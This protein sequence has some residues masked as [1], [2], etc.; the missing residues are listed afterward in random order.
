MSNFFGDIGGTASKDNLWGLKDI[1]ISNAGTAYYLGA[2]Y[3][4][5]QNQS[6]KL[7]LVY[8]RVRGNDVGSRN[9]DRNFSFKSSIFEPTVQY[10]YYLVS[11]EARYQSTSHLYNRNGMINNFSHIGVYVFAGIGG[12][13]YFPRVF[14]HGRAPLPGVETVSG[15]SKMT[16]AIPFGL[17]VKKSI[18]KYWS[19][20]IEFGRRIVF[21]DYL[22]GL[23]TTYSKHNDT[24]YFGIL[25]LIYKLETD[26]K[27]VP[28]IFRR[29]NYLGG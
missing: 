21:S 28:Y 5:K 24:Y 12:A 20:G 11:D 3:K 6:I 29:Y 25:N 15:Y 16:V 7:S 19:V 27:N 9:E 22:D 4:L 2:R 23:S 14:Y 26:R 18:D 10:E 1:S 13:F 17:G 8:G